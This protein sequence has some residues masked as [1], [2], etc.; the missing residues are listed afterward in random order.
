MSNVERYLHELVEKIGPRPVTSDTERMAAEWIADSF[1]EQGLPTEMQDF[2]TNRTTTWSNFIFC[3]VAI[4][5][6]V[7]LGL[8]RKPSWIAWVLWAILVL[9][10]V[11]FHIG[12]NGGQALSKVLAK[13]PSQNVIARYAPQTRGSSTRR[14]KVV[15]VAHYDSL[16]VS[17]LTE[18]SLASVYGV[19]TSINK[20]LI[21][22]LPIL[23]LSMV[24]SFKFLLSARTEAWYVLLVICLV[25]ALLALDL[26]VRGI[27]KRFSSGANNNASG[28]AALLDIAGSLTEGKSDLGENRKQYTHAMN[29][30]QNAFDYDVP[31]QNP[32]AGG[33][34][35]PGREA[36]DFPQDFSWSEG[37][38][39]AS[40]EA[41]EPQASSRLRAAPTRRESIDTN[42]LQFDTIDFA[43]VPNAAVNQPTVSFAPVSSRDAGELDDRT[44]MLGPDLIG[45]GPQPGG[46]FATFD[47]KPSL[48][49]RIRLGLKKKSSKKRSGKNAESADSTD[50]LGLDDGFDARSAGKEIGS[51]D[52]FDDEGDD[53]GFTWKGGAANGDIVEDSD[54]A[55]EQAARIR[56][57]VTETFDMQLDEKEL[58]FVATGAYGVHGFGMKAFLDAYGSELRDAL[59]INVE[60]VGAGSLHWYAQEGAGSPHK[61]SARLVSLARRAARLSEIR[62]KAAKTKNAT[63][64]AT[65][66]LQDGYRAITVTRLDRNGLPVNWRS[67]EDNLQGVDVE[68]IDEVVKFVATMVR[69]A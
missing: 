33:G 13:G 44:E 40:S 2:E 26:L 53:D 16:R 28:V 48:F 50:W 67:M 29:A 59:I 31:M 42:F 3:F 68:L 21:R 10:A 25:P 23:A 34:Y 46:G 37:E 14:K 1:R 49:A 41:A 8:L 61:A 19:L 54:F 32:A 58:W 60:A 43:A 15:V 47:D 39:F 51:W 64:D 69:E 4:A 62:A 52:N 9:D 20:Y 55:A 36:S 65:V 7:V 38:T 24:L 63:T 6:I 35:S 66:A 57:K 45:D 30:V 17:P 12:L 11:G 18:N 22:I 5:C 56:R 27:I